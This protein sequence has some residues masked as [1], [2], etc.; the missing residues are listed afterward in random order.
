V[1]TGIA[2]VAQQKLNCRIVSLA[3]QMTRSTQSHFD[4]LGLTEQDYG[5][6]RQEAGA[7]GC[8]CLMKA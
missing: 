3:H 2:H 8:Y 7:A 1:A 6:M 5:D 4:S